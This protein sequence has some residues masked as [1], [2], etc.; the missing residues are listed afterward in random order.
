[1]GMGARTLV[2]VPVS[3]RPGELIELS[4]LIAHPM[5]TG[6]RVDA[7]GRKLPRNILRRFRCEWLAEGEAPQPLFEAELHPA[8]SANPYIA[9]AM[10]ARRSGTLRFSWEGDQGFSHSESA[11]LKVG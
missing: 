2:K 3:A 6:F 1:M 4:A 11:P 9:F 8:L 7:E 10:V 5:E